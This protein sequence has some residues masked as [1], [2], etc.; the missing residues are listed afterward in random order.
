MI[1]NLMLSFKLQEEN[2]L[3]SNTDWVGR[4]AEKRIEDFIDLNEGEMKLFKL[5]N[6]HMGSLQTTVGVAH[7][8]AVVLR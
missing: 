4:Q 7:M 8:P 2:Y 5:W 3:E 6:S 1:S